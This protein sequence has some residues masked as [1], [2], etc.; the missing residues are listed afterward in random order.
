MESHKPPIITARDADSPESPVEADRAAHPNCLLLLLQKILAEKQ[1]LHLFLTS[2]FVRIFFE[3][4][5]SPLKL[6]NLHT[7]ILRAKKQ[8]VSALMFSFPYTN[9]TVYKY[10]PIKQPSGG[11]T[12][13][14]LVGC[15]Q[16]KLHQYWRI[17]RSLEYNKHVI[18]WRD[19]V[20]ELE[21][22]IKHQNS[23]KEYNM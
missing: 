7:E 2:S 17:W 9:Y 15:I 8:E 11:W 21:F 18:S 1:L 14:K 16:H 5:I 22:S 4:L 6:F 3:G 10:K 12:Q 19:R 13:S 23:R 20:K